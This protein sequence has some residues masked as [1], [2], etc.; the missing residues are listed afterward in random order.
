MYFTT[1]FGG[2]LI[3]GSMDNLQIKPIN[4]LPFLTSILVI[5]SFQAIKFQHSVRAYGD[6]DFQRLQE[7]TRKFPYELQNSTGLKKVFFEF[8]SDI[9]T[10]VPNWNDNKISPN[11]TRAFS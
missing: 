1:S 8:T 7:L 3:I 6:L 5:T 2:L 9:L 11:M 4:Q 10:F